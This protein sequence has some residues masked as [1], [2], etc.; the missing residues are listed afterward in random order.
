MKGCLGGIIGNRGV[1]PGYLAEKGREEIVNV[2]KKQE[3]EP[4]LIQGVYKW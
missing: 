3:I 4:I 1:F 2:L